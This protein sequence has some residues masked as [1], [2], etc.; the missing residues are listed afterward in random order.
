MEVSSHG[1]TPSYH[2]F[3]MGSSMNFPP[4]SDKGVPPLMETQKRSIG[5]AQLVI[6]YVIMLGPGP[7]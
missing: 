3:E 1:G 7:I 4:S 2:P 6:E 5:I